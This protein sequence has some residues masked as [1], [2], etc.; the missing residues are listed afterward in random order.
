MQ[1]RG[2]C[3][4]PNWGDACVRVA[5]LDGHAD[6]EHPC[7]SGSTVKVL[8]SL[9][10]TDEPPSGESAAHGTHVASVLFGQHG[11]EVEGLVPN[12]TGLVI[13]IFSKGSRS[14]SQLDLARA[15]ELAV[16]NGAHVINIS[17]GQLTDF[18]EA[19][20]WLHNAIKL[21]C[22]RNILVVAAAGNDGCECLHVPAALPNVLAV[23][24]LDRRDRPMDFSN[25]GDHYRAGGLMAP[26]EQILGA[27]PGGGTTRANGTSF[28]TPLVSGAAALLLGLQVSKGDE[29]DPLAIRRLLLDTA[30]PCEGSD[31]EYSSRC[32]AGKLNLPGAF[33]ALI[34][35]KQMTNPSTTRGNAITPQCACDD[36]DKAQADSDATVVELEPQTAEHRYSGSPPTGRHPSF[37]QTA[38]SG[39]GAF[40]PSH[41]NGVRPNSIVPSQSPDE[42]EKAEGIVFSIGVLGYDFGTEARRDSFKQLMQVMPPPGPI[43]PRNPYDARQMVDYLRFSPSEARSLIWT[44]NIELTPVYAV[45]PVG[46]FAAEVYEVLRNLLEGEVRAETEIEFVERVSIP[47]LLTGRT[48]RLFS[49][50]VVPVIEVHNVR[51]I[52]GW[53]SNQLVRAAIK[54]V[55]GP[56]DDDAGQVRGELDDFLNR[57]YYDLR[58]LGK[59]SHDRALNFAATNA[60]QAGETFSDPRVRGMQLDEIVVDKSPFCRLDSDCWDVKLK[61]FDPENNQKAKRIMRYTVDV[62]D[63]IPVTLGAVRS[64]TQAN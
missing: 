6:L 41:A 17:G 47:G 3:F 23:G 19:D 48:V 44:L 5:V 63:L 55:G 20:V 1:S 62:S 56:E 54:A 27:K 37:A 30:L 33:E 14:A 49:G 40:M 46:P 52:F 12:C 32:L 24:A 43:P 35:R 64:W 29:P 36:V 57:V 38:R 22:D 50:Q 13:P 42:V 8:N 25:W 58:N 31:S 59:T 53:Q 9:G 7:F 26:G 28:A 51:G 2:P 34:G 39:G 16:E 4:F 60:F 21:C 18:G 10:L 45:E 61:F 15:I 11:S